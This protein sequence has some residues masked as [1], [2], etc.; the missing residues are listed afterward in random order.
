[1]FRSK[2]I[3]LNAKVFITKFCWQSFP[4]YFILFVSL[5]KP[6][7]HNGT[8]LIKYIHSSTGLCFNTAM[9]KKLM[10]IQSCLPLLQTTPAAPFGDLVPFKVSSF[11]LLS[12][13]IV[14]CYQHISDPQHS[15]QLHPSNSWP[16]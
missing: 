14:S 8:F 13:Q 11:S 16:N 7:K 5:I 6:S 10:T 2:L 12:C 9:S 4:I 3:S 1:M 15:L